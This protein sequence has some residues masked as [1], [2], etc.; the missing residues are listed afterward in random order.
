MGTPQGELAHHL[1]KHLYSRTNK[2]NAAKQIGKHVWRLEKA[3][4]AAGCRKLK[5]KA[6]HNQINDDEGLKKDLDI[7]Y[8]ILH[9]KNDPVDICSYIQTNQ[10]NPVFKVSYCLIDI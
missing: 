8:Q 2:W 7:R 3:Q 10:G 9:S 1:V 6:K 4:L 5:E